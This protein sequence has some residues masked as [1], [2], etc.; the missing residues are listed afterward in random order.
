MPQ[1]NFFSADKS[2]PIAGESVLEEAA[3]LADAPS[4]NGGLDPE[5]IVEEA[6]QI[7]RES[8]PH[9]YD[10]LIIGGGPGGYTCAIRAAQLGMRV[11]LVEARKIGGVCVNVG[12]IPA[13]A[14]LESANA[15]K[16]IQRAE[17]FGL[18]LNGSCTADFAAMSA[19]K[20]KIVGEQR[21]HVEELLASLDVEILEGRASFADTHSI[22]ITS[23]DSTRIVRAVHVV[24]AT[25]SRPQHLSVIGGDAAG[26]LT[27]DEILH[28]ETV[29]RRLI[30]IGAGAVGIEFAYLFRVLGSQVT[31]LEM[32]AQIMP[33]EDE[34]VAMELARLLERDG[35]EIITR[36]EVERIE[37]ERT[38]VANAEEEL[39]LH[40]KRDGQEYSLASDRVLVAVGRNANS[41][42]LNLEA[43]GIECDQ[44]KI[45][46]NE[47]C[48]TNVSGVY[49]IGD[50]T[51]NV[52]WAHQ[53]TAEGKMVA[54]YICGLTSSVDLSLIPSCYYTQPEIASVG[55]TL[56]QARKQGITARAGTFYFRASGRAAA[57]GTDDGFVK[58]VIDEESERIIGCQII[59]PRA[60]DLINE[61]LLAIKQG[62]TA[63]EMINSIHT[64]PAFNEA[65]PVAA[66]AALKHH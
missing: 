10:V 1:E 33:G 22:E 66:S 62:Q 38:E 20:D 3:L 12:C 60:T 9:D 59:G 4:V 5:D 61:A 25:G 47:N 26:V 2:T 65:L 32:T 56:L 35:V 7:L 55:L 15:L 13:K 16:L 11:G 28:L 50:C 31:I 58:L 49:A 64:H 19:R 52:G 45:V 48:E 54:E 6:E 27:S 23:S 36:A 44:G 24:I 18:H 51:R 41:D 42:G 57:A 29:P 37:T 14:M 34:D 39:R 43:I 53:A 40:Y 63:S 46:V 8:A 17:E 21:A 30:V